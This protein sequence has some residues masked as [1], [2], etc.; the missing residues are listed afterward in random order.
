MST[1][2]LRLTVTFSF[3]YVVSL[4]YDFIPFA[5]SCNNGFNVKKTG[6]IRPLDMDMVWN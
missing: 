3:T 1:L 4:T 6:K 2:E 5:P